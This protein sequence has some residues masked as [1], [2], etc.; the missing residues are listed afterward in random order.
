[1]KVLSQI[2]IYILIISTQLVFAGTTGRL[3]GRITDAASGE[4]L[5]FVNVVIMG[6]TLGAATDIDG[7]YSIINVP[8]GNYDV[9]ASAIG[10]SAITYQDV[11]ISIDL[12]TTINFEVKILIRFPSSLTDHLAGFQRILFTIRLGRVENESTGEAIIRIISSVH[13]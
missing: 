4:A 3:A 10:Y 11:K 5:P 13:T 8:P 1:M 9:K 2:F 7:Y 6:T 12:T